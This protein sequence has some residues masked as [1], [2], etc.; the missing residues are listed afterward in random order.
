L[1]C[2]AIIIVNSIVNKIMH[3]PLG[4]SSYSNN[5]NFDTYKGLHER[6]GGKYTKYLLM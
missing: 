5:Y 1:C 2:D 6:P 3:R 4:S